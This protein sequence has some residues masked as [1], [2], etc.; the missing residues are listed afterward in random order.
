MGSNLVKNGYNKISE[1]YLQNRDQFKN[2]KYLGKFVKLLKPGAKILDLGCG[3]GKPID[4]FLIKKGFKIIGLD[5]S[6]KQIELAKKN[7]PEG[8]FYLKDMSLLKRGEY[9]VDAIV[10]FYAI[11]HIPRK[12]HFELFEKIN[13]FLPKDGLILVTM[14][15]SGWEGTEDDF[16]GAKMYWSHYDSEKNRKIIGKAGFDILLDEIDTSGGEKHQIIIGK[17]K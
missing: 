6:K 1:K 10:S 4:E 2:L 11:F 13:S 8:K 17:K 15:S 9:Q 5:I 14:G 3:A 12:N 7:V 16:H